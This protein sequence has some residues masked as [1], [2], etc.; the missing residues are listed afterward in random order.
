MLLHFPG[1][2]VDR[3]PAMDEWLNITDHTPDEWDL[4]L[5]QTQYPEKV[6][7][8]WDKFPIVCNAVMA[9]EESIRSSPPRT[10]TY[11]RS[12]AISDLKV[13]LQENADRREALQTRLDQL[14]AAVSKE[15]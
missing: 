2:E 5:N 7:Q 15:I 3:W 8:F 14:H 1:I 13:A 4:P 6:S 11:A 10:P 12:T 9:A